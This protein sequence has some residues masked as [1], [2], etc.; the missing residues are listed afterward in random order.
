MTRITRKS[1]N[2]SSLRC[3]CLYALH[4]CAHNVCVTNDKELKKRT[5]FAWFRIKFIDQHQ[6][7]RS[8]FVNDRF[9]FSN[10]HCMK[11]VIEKFKKSLLFKDF[12]CIC[13]ITNPQN[14]F[15][16][17]EQ[18]Q[19]KQ[20]KNKHSKVLDQVRDGLAQM[21]NF[22]R[23]F[24]MMI[25]RISFSNFLVWDNVV[26]L[27]II[28]QHA[29]EKYN[30]ICKILIR[31][32]KCL[33]TIEIYIEAFS[34]SSLIQDCVTDLYCFLFRFWTKVCKIYHRRH[35]WK[36]RR[37]WNNFDV[38]FD[39]FDNN[40][41]K[42]QKLL[43]KFAVVIRVQNSTKIIKK[44]KFVNAFVLKTQNWKHKKD[45]IV[46]FVPTIFDVNYYN[47][48]LININKICH[49]NI[50]EWML[51]KNAF[52]EFNQ[53]IL[54]KKSL[55]WIYA[56]PEAKNRILFIFF[57]EYFCVNQRSRSIPMLYFFLSQHRC[58]KKQIDCDLMFSFLSTIS[59]TW[60]TIYIPVYEWNF[61]FDHDGVW[62]KKSHQFS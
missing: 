10:D 29:I 62:P 34:D 13:S 61:D 5:Q 8:V 27:L 59:S 33:S 51:N 1:A 38:K 45:I 26:F 41:I 31:M 49:V 42:Y 9:S 20:V 52:I 12:S 22:N 46:W 53:N 50:C 32:I 7:L 24:D 40:M 4:I 21:Q 55:L 30:K 60:Q 56:Q 3:A 54:Q 36:F 25:Q 16:E 6:R 19:A 44:Q 35:L 48:D 11:N 15:K 47:N 18:W 17:F 28:L 57:I 2:C 39:E 58:E 14:L 23:A 37:I 43:K